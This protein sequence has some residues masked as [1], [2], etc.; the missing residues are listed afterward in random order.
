M[1]PLG[2]LPPDDPRSPID[3]QLDREIMLPTKTTM[4]I[5]MLKEVIKNDCGQLERESTNEGMSDG[6]SM[7]DIREV[8]Q[9]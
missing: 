3:W 7:N 1:P 5:N 6:R 8:G 2:P 9:V 4:K